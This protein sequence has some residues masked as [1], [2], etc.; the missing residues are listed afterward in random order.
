[1]S[2]WSERYRIN[3]WPKSRR[4][5]YIFWTFTASRYLPPPPPPPPERH[6]L[7]PFGPGNTQR[8]LLL[9]CFYGSIRPTSCGSAPL[10]NILNATGWVL[11][12]R[13]HSKKQRL[14]TGHTGPL[15]P[16][17]IWQPKTIVAKKSWKIKSCYFMIYNHNYV[18]KRKWFVEE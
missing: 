3:R 6:S 8:S 5:R 18:M 10:F 1:M 4:K 12:T 9:C 16:W 11:W 2:V 17:R 13:S 15:D 14:F 7:G